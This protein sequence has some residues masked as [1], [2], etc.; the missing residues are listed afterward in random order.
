MSKDWIS[1]KERLPEPNVPV[2]IY[3]SFP[4][5]IRFKIVV[6]AFDAEMKKFRPFDWVGEEYYEPNCGFEK[7]DVMY[8]M[9]LPE[10][11][12]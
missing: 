5:E 11:P 12:I 7:D 9:P 10:F 8:W 6:A 2:L 4:K 3:N 1:I